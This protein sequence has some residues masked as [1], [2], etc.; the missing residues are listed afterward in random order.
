M[1]NVNELL[2]LLDELTQT[3]FEMQNEGAC[4]ADLE[5]I[6]KEI[7]ATERELEQ[8]QSGLDY[9][10]VAEEA[11]EAPSTDE[12][13]DSYLHDCKRLGNEPDQSVIN[14]ILS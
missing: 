10:L 2:E 14:G 11:A 3:G 6:S 12:Q 13:L 4:E 8:S 9:N 5:E 7:D 1:A